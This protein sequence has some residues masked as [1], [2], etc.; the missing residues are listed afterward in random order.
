MRRSVFAFTLVG[1]A[2]AAMAQPGWTPPRLLRGG[3]GAAPWN[4]ESGGIAA[5]EV[6]L[7]ENGR[8]SAVDVVQDVAPYGAQLSD[9]V[10]SW[11]FEA[12][13]EGDRRV[14]ARVLVLGFFRPPALSIQ[15]PEKPR[16]KTTEA[17]PE[18]P[19]P[20][21]VAVPPYPANV[22]GSGVVVMEAD[23]S[24]QGAVT[25]ARVVGP[26]SP[27]DSAARDAA[28]L[29]TYRPAARAGREV[30]SRVYLLFS[31]IGVTP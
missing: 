7:D 27:F 16:Y 10:R 22:V 5:C 8:V 18:L 15:T 1:L 26:A 30:A 23:V 19:W 28:G 31:F 2:V 11:E 29:W 24:D 14:P 17:P 9:A 21:F 25:S 20:T 13:R 3:I 4:V 6:S 12:A